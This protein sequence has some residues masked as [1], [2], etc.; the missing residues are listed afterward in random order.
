V[1]GLIE[2]YALIGDMQTA[3]LAGRD[4]SIDWLCLPRFDSPACFASLL[5][6]EDHGYWRIAPAGARPDGRGALPAADGAGSGPAGRAEVTRHYQGD[7]LVLQTDWRTATG[8]VGLIDFMPPRDGKSPMLIRIVEGVHG[9]VDVECDLRIRL[10]YGQILPWVRRMDG[11]IVAVAGPDSLWLDTPVTMSGRNMAH[12]ASFRVAAGERV[13]FTLTWELIQRELTSDGLVR[14]YQLASG[15]SDV[16]GLSGS[17]G[18]FLACSFW[19]VNA[20]HMTG[21]TDDAHELFERLLSLR[22]DVGLLS[23]EYDPRYHRQV[24][25]TPQA[26]SHVPLV[27]AALNLDAHEPDHCRRPAG[28]VTHHGGRG[29]R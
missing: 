8:T 23:E 9:H 22:N 19:M 15:G 6:T 29:R 10:G 2:D 26:F 13:P 3:A 18:A 12:H 28:R 4:G 21:K 14:R 25:N 27:Q 7:T 11:R 17:E 16:D 5:G 1:A 24:G 20:L